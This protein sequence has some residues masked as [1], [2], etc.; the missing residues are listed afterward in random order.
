MKMLVTGGAGFIGS[1]IVARLLKEN[2]SVVVLDNF[3]S[4]KESN[5][6]FAMDRGLSTVDFTLIRGDIRDYE[7]CTK[8]CRGVDVIFHQAALRS[9]PRSMEYP[10]EYNDVN[11]N[12]TL[13]LLRAAVES[14]ARK[15]VFA[16]SSSIYGKTDKFPE[17]ENEYPMPISPYAL[18]KLVGEY[19]CKIYAGNFNLHT[20][21]L[22]YFNVFGPRQALDDDYAVVIPKFI[23]CMLNDEA[24]PIH[25]TGRQSR[26]FTYIEDVVTANI[27]AA[28]ADNASGEVF[29]VAN[30][31]THSILSLVDILNR[32]LGK[33]IAP[34]FTP[35]R[36]GDVP[37]SLADTA[38][39]RRLLNFQGTIGFEE[40]LRRTVEYFEDSRRSVVS[41]R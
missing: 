40:G 26:D 5:L 21:A 39:A 41:S 29:N 25:G 38:K 33:S 27:C 36:A 8:A 24:P 20:V 11:I 30:G 15:F 3:F 1:H 34:V 28:Q 10:Q 6:S 2:H 19:Y 13:N 14:D 18:T 31:R 4:G 16:S 22:R 7:A 17:N 12:G 9:V 23:S 32:I 37:K 35:A